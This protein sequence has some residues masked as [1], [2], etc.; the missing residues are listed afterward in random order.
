[1]EVNVNSRPAFDVYT[2]GCGQTVH[3]HPK[4]RC[5]GKY[6]VIHRPWPGPWQDWPTYWDDHDKIMYRICDHDFAHVVAEDYLAY[7]RRALEHM[8]SCDCVCAPTPAQVFDAGGVQYG[9]I[10]EGQIVEVKELTDG[11]Q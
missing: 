3:V 10:W 1:M 11:T 7:D 8:D 2:T 6:C 5:R 4:A 9:L